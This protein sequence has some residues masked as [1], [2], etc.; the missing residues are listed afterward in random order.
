[1]ASLWGE[2]ATDCVMYKYF[3]AL[4][5]AVV[6][7]CW[8]RSLQDVITHK[9]ALAR[10]APADTVTELLMT[11]LTASHAHFE[12]CLLLRRVRMV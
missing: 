4:R 12:I 8:S 3:D 1:M 11:R 7:P 6:F 9:M 10:R 5:V 2:E